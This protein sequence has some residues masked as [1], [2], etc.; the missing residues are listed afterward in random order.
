MTIRRAV[1]TKHLC[2][3]I[4][5]L[6]LACSAG[7]V[8]GG[9]DGGGT[10]DGGGKTDGG[11]MTDGGGDM[12][13]GLLT[14]PKCVSD[15]LAA[16]PPIVPCVY[17]LGDG[18]SESVC[19]AV[20]ADGG[21]GVAGGARATVT[22]VPVSPTGPGSITTVTKTSG[23]PCYSFEYLRPTQYDDMVSTWTWKDA[24]GRVVA[25]GSLSLSPGPAVGEFSNV[26]VITC[27]TGDTETSCRVPYGSMPRC[28]DVYYG[29]A[30]CPDGVN[31]SP[32]CAA[33]GCP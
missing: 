14:L 11:G 32:A 13:G 20:G 30:A 10:T 5:V 22:T 33:G 26:G 29:A 23:S 24:N 28:C 16:C 4:V 18:G 21:L 8:K 9:L 27:A 7:T 25:S 17:S 3:G 31:P 6:S 19:F 1:V 12:N 15:L 2:G